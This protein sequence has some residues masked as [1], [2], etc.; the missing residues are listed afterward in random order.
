[1]LLFTFRY[2]QYFTGENTMYIS[3]L[4]DICE[5]RRK[6]EENLMHFY[7]SIEF[8]CDPTFNIINT[9]KISKNMGYNRGASSYSNSK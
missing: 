1:M 2:F 9:T 4:E 3:N 7:F 6:L 8:S 5:C